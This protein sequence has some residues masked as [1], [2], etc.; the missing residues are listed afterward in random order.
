MKSSPPLALVAFV[1][2]TASCGAAVDFSFVTHGP[3]SLGGDEIPPRPMQRQGDDLILPLRLR[4]RPPVRVALLDLRLFVES[5]GQEDR[6]GISVP[7]YPSA[8]SRSIIPV[9][10]RPEP[11]VNRILRFEAYQ[12][13][14]QFTKLRCLWIGVVP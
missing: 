7:P 5:G 6:L 8:V 3:P 14:K 12:G 10:I 1:L 9:T 11:P 13:A 2:S 4:A